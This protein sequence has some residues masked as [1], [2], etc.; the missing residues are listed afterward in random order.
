VL[1]QNWHG[2]CFVHFHKKPIALS[3]RCQK[4]EG[5]EEIGQVRFGTPIAKAVGAEGPVDT[6]ETFAAIHLNS[7]TMSRA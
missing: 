6:S 7:S 5:T 3:T 2:A 4:N 1:F